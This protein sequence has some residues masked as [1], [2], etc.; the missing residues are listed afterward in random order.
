MPASYSPYDIHRAINKPDQTMEKQVNN[1]NHLINQLGEMV[2]DKLGADDCC[3]GCRETKCD[4]RGEVNQPPPKDRLEAHETGL[5]K[6]NRVFLSTTHREAEMVRVEA[7]GQLSKAFSQ[8][9]GATYGTY[10]ELNEA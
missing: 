10:I 9:C 3:A 6:L 5:E 7:L 1:L 2:V 4:G 8:S